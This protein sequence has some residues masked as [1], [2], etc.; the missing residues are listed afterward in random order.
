M[1]AHLPALQIALPLMAAP[2]CLLLRKRQLVLGFGILVC[3]LSFA[4]S[5]GLVRQTLE[6]GE[7]V[8]SLGGWDAPWGI[9]Y[10]ID[11]LNASMLALVSLIAAI[12]LTYAPASLAREIPESKQY[13]F[14]P[15]YLLSMTGLM[16]IAI[17]GDL[18]NVFVFLEVSSLSSYALISLGRDR[19]A[20]T[21][22][23][24]YLVL[25]TIGA[26]FILISIGLL[27]MMTGTLNMADMATRIGAM[28]SMRTVHAAFAFF[29]VGVGLKVALFPLHVWLP[30]AYTY[31]PS[32]VTAF[33][34]ATSTKVSVYVLLR[35]VFSV[36]GYEFAFSS[37]PLDTMLLALSLLGIF[38]AS[39]VAIFQRNIKRMLAY[40][41]VAQVG[42]MVL[43]ISF[44]SVS[45]L[46]GAIVHIF[47]HALMKGGLFLAM[48]C[49]VLRIGSARID[50]MAGLGKRMPLTMFAWV[51]GGLS[52]I[53]VPLTVGF[54]SKWYLIEAALEKDLWWVAGLALLSSLLAVLY[55]WRVVE[56]AYFREAPAGAQ[57]EEAPL[58]M[59]IPTWL[60]IGASVLF[61]IRTEWTAGI[62][63]KAAALLLGVGP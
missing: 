61:G 21:A 18:F 50:D 14:V 41:S 49:I 30:N 3:W 51:L 52:L 60:L 4:V 56:V 42:Y 33:L 48:G 32:V 54:V 9:E 17:T 24:Q 47:N 6:V 45:G 11:L 5:V 53:G 58:S 31:A 16:G 28:E 44:A 62:A 23:L 8:Y 25:G 46:T 13:L 27:Y 57:R 1:S 20:L 12:V 55:V 37:M 22:T 35:F 19:R 39:A 7:I 26:T 10:R 29:C 43:G 15:A 63:Q 59:L 2:F 36:Y 34:A 38:V 40:S